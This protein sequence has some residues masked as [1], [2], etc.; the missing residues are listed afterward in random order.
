VSFASLPSFSSCLH[1]PEWWP[2]GPCSRALASPLRGQPWRV[3][4]RAFSGHEMHLIEFALVSSL[5]VCLP[6]GK[7]W[8]LGPYPPTL[9]SPFS[10]SSMVSA[11]RNIPRP[12][13]ALR[14]VLLCPLI[15]PMLFNL[16]TKPCSTRLGNSDELFTAAMAALSSPP[17]LRWPA[18][19]FPPPSNPSRSSRDQRLRKLNTPSGS[20][21]AK[22]TS[23]FHLFEPAVLG[24][25]PKYAFSFQIRSFFG[26]NEKYVFRLITEL[27]L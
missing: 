22:E 10:L 12:R 21:F 15:I 5:S 8:P 14:R 3:P 11:V 4:N 9:A 13:N 6:F 2:L 17:Q 25:F 24:V 26:L 16:K 23:N 19:L 7:P 27:P 20:I 18:P 1:F